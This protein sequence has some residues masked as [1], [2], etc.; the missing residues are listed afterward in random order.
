MI[1]DGTATTTTLNATS[2][3]QPADSTNKLCSLT[4]DARDA[5]YN[6]LRTRKVERQ[7]RSIKYTNQMDKNVVLRAMHGSSRFATDIAIDFIGRLT[8]GTYATHPVTFG[9][10]AYTVATLMNGKITSITEH[11][12]V[13]RFTVTISANITNLILFFY[14]H[15]SIW[16][17]TLRRNRRFIGF[18]HKLIFIFM[19]NSIIFLTRRNRL[20]VISRYLMNWFCYM[21]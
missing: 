11:Q 12:L 14:F 16:F 21:S 17:L 5:L 19:L 10:R 18:Y 15:I 9:K 1:G 7:L 20:I 6:Y 3:A 4:R 13:I 2:S 8:M